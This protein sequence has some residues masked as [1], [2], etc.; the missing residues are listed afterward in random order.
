MI[1]KKVE[2]ESLDRLNRI[3]GQVKG[4]GNMVKERRY[5][6]DII[7]QI[8]AAEAA[9]HKLSEI[10]LEN[11]IKTCVNNAFKSKNEKDMQEKID[12]LI[13][14]YASCRIK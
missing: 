8:K 7:T 2:K 6:I 10:L 5:C 4:I 13:N 12:E 3:E 14:V 1:D 9:L 11:H